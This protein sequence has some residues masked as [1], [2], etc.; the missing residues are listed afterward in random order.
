MGHF[1]S[2]CWHYRDVSCQRHSVW[3]Y[4]QLVCLFN[5]LISIT[6]KKASNL[7]ITE[8]FME[9]R[10]CH[11]DAH[12]KGPLM[13]KSCLC[14]D[15]ILIKVKWQGI[16]KFTAEDLLISSHMVSFSWSVDYT[17]HKTLCRLPYIWTVL[18]ILLNQ[19]Y[20]YQVT[21]SSSDAQ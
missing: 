4:R 10:D 20:G 13:R 14:S 6:T 9:I 8:H 1:A 17:Q 16:C 12:H 5:S 19:I 15:F 3:N 18:D 7:R 21:L 11:V 2:R